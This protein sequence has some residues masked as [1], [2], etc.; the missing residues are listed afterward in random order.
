MAQLHS[1][2][3]L[4][5]EQIDEAGHGNDSYRTSDRDNF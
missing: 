4:E 1:S 3:R 5:G 2:S